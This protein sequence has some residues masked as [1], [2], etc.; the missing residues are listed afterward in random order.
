MHESN[1]VTWSWEPLGLGSLPFRHSM[2][3]FV[4]CSLVCL[5]QA[6]STDQVRHDT[7]PRIEMPFGKVRP[8]LSRVHPLE[9]EIS[10]KR[11][12]ELRGASVHCVTYLLIPNSEGQPSASRSDEAATRNLLYDSLLLPR[13]LALKYCIGV[14]ASLVPDRKKNLKKTLSFIPKHSSQVIGDYHFHT[15]TAKCSLR[16]HGFNGSDPPSY[17]CRRPQELYGICLKTSSTLATGVYQILRGCCPRRCRC[18]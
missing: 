15:H 17:R 8:G 11:D 18:E 6:A 3:L 1:A 9:A 12:L 16:S 10:V 14:L 7:I 2:T 13:P 5:K 4:N